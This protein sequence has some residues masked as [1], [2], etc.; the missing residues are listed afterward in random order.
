MD[1][2]ITQRAAA[3]E[4][5]TSQGVVAKAVLVARHDP[6]MLDKILIGTTTLAAAYRS[7][8]EPD[9]CRADEPALVRKPPIRSLFYDVGAI[10]RTDP[11]PRR[12]S[13]PPVVLKGGVLRR[14]AQE[15]ADATTIGLLVRFEDEVLAGQPAATIGSHHGV[16]LRFARWLQPRTLLDATPHDVTRWLDGM[17]LAGAWREQRAAILARFYDWLLAKGLIEQN[18]ATRSIQDS[19]FTPDPLADW[20][21][22]WR[23]AQERRGLSPETI[24]WRKGEIKRFGRFVGPESVLDATADDIF[25][26][27]DSRGQGGQ[28]LSLHTRRG[29]IA[30]LRAFYKWAKREGLINVAPTDRIEPP[31]V[32]RR[33][34]RPIRDEDLA[35]A[36]ERADDTTRAVLSLAAFCGLRTKE[37]AGLVR[38]GHLRA[39][40]AAGGDRDQSERTSPTDRATPPRSLGSGQGNPAAEWPTLHGASQPPPVRRV[41]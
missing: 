25:R 15:R 8:Q 36:L 38:G 27:L 2:R 37:I 31:R 12:Y 28:P 10:A 14:P 35:V 22:R 16:V 39:R 19:S 9:R 29:G 5:S 33:L 6:S 3:R 41:E 18:P 24:R 1:R 21:E 7:L 23:I 30:T 13:S 32:M 11:K 20:L 17:A 34:G 26:W 4:A 40:R